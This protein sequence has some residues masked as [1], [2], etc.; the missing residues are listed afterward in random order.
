MLKSNNKVAYKNISFSQ[1]RFLTTRNAR[2]FYLWCEQTQVSVESIV[3]EGHI[4]QQTIQAK[5]FAYLFM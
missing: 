4:N 3:D 1:Y 5:Y 2:Q